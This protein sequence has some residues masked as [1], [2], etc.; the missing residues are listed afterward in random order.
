MPYSLTSATTLGFDLVRRPAGH[1]VAD[2]L[3]TAMAVD[4]ELV[5]RLA[6]VHPGAGSDYAVDGR[7]A[8]ELAAGVPH[9]GSISTPSGPAVNPSALLRSLTRSTVGNAAAAE[10]LLRE[11]ILGAEHPAAFAGDDHVWA[12]ATDVLADAAI[13]VWASDV[14]PAHLAHRL[15]AP[16]Q[17]VDVASRLTGVLDL[18]PTAVQLTALLTALEHLGTEHRQRWRRTVDDVRARRRPWAE[19]MHSACW[20]AN[21]AGRVRAVAAAQLLAVSAFGRG[22]FGAADAG[23]GVWNVL[24]GCVQGLA[25]AD[26][27]DEAT[28]DTLTQPWELATG[29]MLPQAA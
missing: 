27:L 23:Y 12:R 3:L 15:T 21:L 14:L 1:R 17:A 24:S 16:L 7:R 29:S 18:G 10:R 13:G 25:L 28:L 6:D 22:G 5:H 19:A 20:A 4:G 9:L 2:V 8:R 11:D 26:L